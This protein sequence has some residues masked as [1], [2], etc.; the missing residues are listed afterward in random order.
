MKDT[1]IEWARHTFN[2]IRGTLTRLDVLRFG[3][4]PG[5]GARS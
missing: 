2:P 1:R 3:P 4:A 5:V